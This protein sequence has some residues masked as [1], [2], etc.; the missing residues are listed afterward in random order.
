METD[1]QQLHMV[2]FTLPES[3]VEEVTPLLVTHCPH[4]WQEAG[5]ASATQRTFYLYFENPLDATHLLQTLTARWPEIEPQTGGVKKEQWASAWKRFFT[6]IDIAHRFRVQPPWAEPINDG[7]EPLVIN[8]QMAFGTGHHATTSLCLEALVDLHASGRIQ[9]GDRFLDAGTGSGILGIACTKLGLTGL[10][11]D[12]DPLTLE[13]IHENKVLNHVGPAF[14]A[15]VGTI[16]CVQA[17]SGFDLILANILAAPLIS[18]APAL[19]ARLR[20]GGCLVLSGLLQSQLARVLA[21]YEDQGLDTPSVMTRGDW[22]CLVF[23]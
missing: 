18:L 20:S 4:G 1:T 12:L 11:F 3:L 6:Q 7:L 17:D 9:E 23:A 16:D 14:S 15:F 8:P 19:T 5:G 21:A 10:G 13:N 2:G 22:A